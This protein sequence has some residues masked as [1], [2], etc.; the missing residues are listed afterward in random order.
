MSLSSFSFSSW[1]I[2]RFFYHVYSQLR[3]ERFNEELE[4]YK[5]QVEE[6]TGFGEIA[7]TPKYLKK[8]QALTSESN[9]P[10]LRLKLILRKKFCRLNIE[11]GFFQQQRRF[12]PKGFAAFKPSKRFLRD[13]L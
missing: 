9:L 13:I 8:T 5:K 3:R 11:L 10:L 12:R 6:F 1:E 7:E 4:G 2:Y